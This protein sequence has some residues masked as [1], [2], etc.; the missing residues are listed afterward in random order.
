MNNASVF[1][2]HCLSI[3][4]LKIYFFQYPTLTQQLLFK[5]PAQCVSGLCVYGSFSGFHVER[6]LFVP[7]KSRVKKLTIYSGNVMLVML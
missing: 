4:A 1:S 5:A 7:H 3:G 6:N 2:L